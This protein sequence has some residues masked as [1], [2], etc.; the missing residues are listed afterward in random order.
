MKDYK[1]VPAV[2]PSRLIAFPLD[3]GQV[4]RMITDQDAVQDLVDRSYDGSSDESYTTETAGINRFGFIICL[5]TDGKLKVF[6]CPTLKDAEAVFA[7]GKKLLSKGG[8]LA[9]Y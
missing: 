2:K 4:R 9:I 3:R 6:E 1:K 7:E 8:V 5:K